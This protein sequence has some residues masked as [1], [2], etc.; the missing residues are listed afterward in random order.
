MDQ[1][2]VRIATVVKIHQHY[3]Y[4]LSL[5]QYSCAITE[6]SVIPSLTGEIFAP[7]ILGVGKCIL[8]AFQYS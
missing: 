7:S 8:V 2:L 1:K 4:R 3:Y 5:R 6:T